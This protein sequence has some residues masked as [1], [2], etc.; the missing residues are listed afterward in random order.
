MIFHRY[1]L[2]NE[3]K[4]VF[5]LFFSDLLAGLS[6]FV[7]MNLLLE[8]TPLQV[9]AF[10]IPLLILGA[11]IPIRKTKRKGIVRSHIKKFIQG[12]VIYDPRNS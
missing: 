10:I 6:L 5:G 3:R 1:R 4:G 2:L 9:S 12:E 8:N 7:V 11:L